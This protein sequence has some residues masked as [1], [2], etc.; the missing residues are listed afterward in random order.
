MFMFRGALLSSRAGAVF[1]FMS[2][3]Y[4]LG[5]VTPATRML[6]HLPGSTP[7]MAAILHASYEAAWLLI[8]EGARLDVRNARQ[9]SAA[10]LAREVGVPQLIQEALDGEV[11]YC[12]V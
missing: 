6:H 4:R 3:K 12:R 9:C 10:D 5:K 8:T 7:L 1:G 11:V 2:L